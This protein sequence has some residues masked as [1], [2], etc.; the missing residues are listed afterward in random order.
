MNRTS[1][2]LLS[3]LALVGLAGMTSRADA[4]EY[5]VVTIYF[6]GTNCTSDMWDVNYHWDQP[7]TNFGAGNGPWNIWQFFGRNRSA[8]CN[9]RQGREMLK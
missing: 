5:Y 3:A 8:V 2:L 6:G 1:M 7:P 9:A 4:P